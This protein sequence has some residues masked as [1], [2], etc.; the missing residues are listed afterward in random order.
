MATSLDKYRDIFDKKAFCH[1]PPSAATAAPRS[2]RCGVTST[3]RTFAST[4]RA[5]A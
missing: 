5:A 4:R 1:S 2:R 3:V